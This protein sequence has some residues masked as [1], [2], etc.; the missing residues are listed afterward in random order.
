MAEIINLRTAR[1]ARAR[2]EAQ[3]RAAENRRLHGRT[4]QEKR[5]TQDEIDRRETLLDGAR[6]EEE[7]P[8]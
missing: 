4:K 1:K 8:G 3:A 6:R 2:A 7:T 5:A